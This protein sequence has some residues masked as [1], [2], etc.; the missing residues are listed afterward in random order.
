MFLSAGGYHHHIGTNVWESKN[1][2]PPPE[3]SLGLN[4]F[5][6][7][8][9]DE[10]YIKEIEEKA[11]NSG[12]ETAKPDNGKILLRDFDNNKIILTL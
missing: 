9:P 10:N 4:S 7:K 1:G 8:L 3:N 5:T 12:I 2:A 6:I 11:K